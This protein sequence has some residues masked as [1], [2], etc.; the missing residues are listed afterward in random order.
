MYVDT[1]HICYGLSHLL[2]VISGHGVK[3]GPGPQDLGP[4]DP[5]IRDPGA[6]AKFKSGARDPP[7]V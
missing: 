3:V 1:I 2:H 6:P 4:R 7:K 5:G